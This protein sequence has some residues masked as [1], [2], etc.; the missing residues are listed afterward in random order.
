ML[1]PADRTLLLSLAASMML[2]GGCWQATADELVIHQTVPF[3]CSRAL[4]TVNVSTEL[5]LLN[6]LQFLAGT[7]TPALNSVTILGSLGAAASDSFVSLRQS[8]IEF[9]AG[10]SSRSLRLELNGP[11]ELICGKPFQVQLSFR[12]NGDGPGTQLFHLVLN[13]GGS[14]TKILSEEDRVSVLEAI[15]NK[16]SKELLLYMGA[17]FKWVDASKDNAELRWKLCSV[18]CFAAPET[19]LSTDPSGSSLRDWN[20]AD[21]RFALV[22]GVPRLYLR[23]RPREI[24]ENDRFSRGPPF[25][26]LD[27][28]FVFAANQTSL[29]LVDVRSPI[30]EFYQVP[31]SDERARKA[32]SDE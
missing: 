9:R 4:A 16:Y 27:F 14:D 22:G 30:K 28:V 3:D 23:F 25:S 31:E 10:Y 32:F 13:F 18:V 12:Y 21:Y 6:D 1:G 20:K 26:L 24:Q 7:D 11:H 2:F 8:N 5:G 15:F 29:E 17:D 19:L